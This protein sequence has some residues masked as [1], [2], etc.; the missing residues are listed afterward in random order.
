MPTPSQIRAARGLLNWSQKDLAERAG[1]TEATVRNAEKDGATPNSK[2]LAAI[3]RA[4]DGESIVF[5]N[6]SGVEQRKDV[7][8]DYEGSQGFVDFMFD[9]YL[10]A[11]EFG[12]VICLHNARPQNWIKW[13]G[14]DEYD[15]H[16]R[17]M[18]EL[19]K[20]IEVR[21][22][23]EEGNLLFIANKFAEYRW[24]PKEWFNEKSIY[25]YGDKLALMDF[26]DNS[27]NIRVLKNKEFTDSVK[28]L[29]NIAWDSVAIIPPN[30]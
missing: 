29:F 1:V 3:T 27:V 15:K 30:K 23:A 18:E 8:V 14:Q 10:G 21:I 13:M 5:I 16:S 2:T 25:M 26:E 4:F 6:K 22:T 24:F 9:V 20:S 7:I 17:R 11:K 28:I 12:G 19:G